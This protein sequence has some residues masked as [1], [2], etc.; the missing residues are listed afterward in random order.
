MKVYARPANPRERARPVRA[1]LI[2]A[3]LIGAHVGS[4]TADAPTKIILGSFW[5]AQAEHGGFYQALAEGTYRKYGL[6]VSIKMGG[7]QVNAVQLLVSGVTDFC[8]AF[9]MQV[10][11]AAQQEIPVVAVEASF[12]KDPQVIIAH[13]WA[14]SL[15]D[16]RGK[17]LLVAAA[18]DVTFWPWLKMKFGY[19]DDMKR[20]YAFNIAPF[21]VDSNIAQQGY[22]T[23]EPYSLEGRG[24]QARV[25]LLPDFGY[26]PYGQVIATTFEMTV[27]HPDVVASFVR[28]SVEGWRSYLANPGPGNALIKRDNPQMTDMQLAYSVQKIRLHKL[29]TGGD[30]ASLGIGTMTDA[31]WKQTFD[32]MVGSG[33]VAASLDYRKAYTLRFIK[34]IHVVAP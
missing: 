11:K 9:D 31:R 32:F 14:R 27:K 1:L 7:P 25:F 30:A 5:Y 12:Q 4:A 28:A 8:L 20:P 13:S 16:L 21:L 10:L 3:L 26:P 22:L 2:I 18:A 33:M 6:D 19:S 23:A 29:V 15:G 17:P 24:V 34:D